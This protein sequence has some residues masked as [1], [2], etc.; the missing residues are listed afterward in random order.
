MPNWMDWFKLKRGPAIPVCQQSEIGTVRVE[1]GC[2][3]CGDPSFPDEMTRIEGIPSG[4]HPVYALSVRYPA[5]FS[6]LA[7][8]GIRFRPGVTDS[9]RSIGGICVESGMAVVVDCDVI[10]KYW[11]DVGPARI[12]IAY[13]NTS[14]LVSKLIEKKFGVK[15][16]RYSICSLQS[17][18]PISEQLEEQITAYLQTFP[19]FA[20]YPFLHFSILTENSYD[21][22]AAS[23]HDEA[24]TEVE[25]DAT[26]HAALLVMSSGY[27][28]GQYDLQGLFQGETLLGMECKFFGAEMD[29][30][31]TGAPELRY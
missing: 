11:T 15:W 19:E 16:V 8:F 3:L 2:L 31:L 13:G 9:Q 4:E 1:S 23:L 17:V 18:Q 21:R 30:V 28:D 24:W 27:G 12:G 5:G 6:R 20:K 7:K 29:E 14:P 26:S 22:V 10:K 25:L